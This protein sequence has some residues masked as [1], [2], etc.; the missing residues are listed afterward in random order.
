MGMNYGVNNRLGKISRE[1]SFLILSKAHLSGIETLD[2]AEAYGDAHDV[3]GHFHRAQHD[4]KFKI[5]TKLPHSIRD[6]EINIRVEE[7]LKRL[8]VDFLDVLMF[9]SFES[10]T[11]NQNAIE[12]LLEMQ[13]KGLIKNIGV[14]VYSNSQIESLLHENAINVVQLPFNLLD[15]YSVRGNLIERLKA[16]GKIV[17]TRSVFLQGLFFKKSNSDNIIYQKLKSELGILNRIKIELG[18][19]MEQ[20]ALSYCVQQPNIDYVLIGVDSVEHLDNN[21]TSSYYSIPKD[22]VKQIDSIEVI[23]IEA[24]NPSLWQ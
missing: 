21:L 7:Y 24:L 3:I 17:H 12:S 22:R 1:E 14:S 2:T 15:N 8:G 10:Y 4:I 9:H 5:I 23:D 20:L 18:C 6:N 13:A 16:S 19:S 11:K